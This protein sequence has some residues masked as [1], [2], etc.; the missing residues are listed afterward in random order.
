MKSS[1]ALPVLVVLLFSIFAFAGATPEAQPPSAQPASF[2]TVVD[3]FLRTEASYNLS[4]RKFTPVVETYLQRLRP[5][6]DFGFAPKSDEYFLGRLEL[7]K[8]Q[9][10]TSM[11]QQPGFL[12]RLVTTV[13]RQFELTFE[14]LG[15]ADMIYV[16][17]RG[18]DREHYD[19]KLARREFLG[20][21][22]CYVVDVTPK[23]KSGPGR[24][25][26]RIWVEDQGYNIVRA[27]GLFS[28][29]IK[30]NTYFLHFDSWRLNL[31]PNLW[32]PAYVYVEESDRDY[33][34]R[35]VMHLKA[36]TRFWGYDL[37]NPAK[38][39]ELAG[40]TIESVD[41]VSDQSGP[42]QDLSP[43]QAQRAW[44]RMAED[45]VLAR[46]EKA[47]L[48]APTGE[49]DKV[50]ATVVNNL[51]ITNNLNLQFDV[52]ARV[53]LTTPLESF[54]VGNTI[55]I[56]RGLLDVLPDEATLAAVLAHELAHITLGHGFDSKYAF[57]DRVLFPDEATLRKFEFHRSAQ[58][59]SDAD[60]QALIYLQNSPYKD[61]LTNVGLFLES[62]RSRQ[63]Q[64][65]NLIR[66]HLGTPIAQ[67]KR[68]RMSS[69]ME[70]APKL[71]PR[72]VDQIASLPLGGRIR[73]DP[74]SDRIELY[75]REAVPLSFPKEK[76]PFEVTPVYP[77]LTRIH[78]PEPQKVTGG[79]LGQ[80]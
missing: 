77:Y 16:D 4:V 42:G 5:D 19:F 39:E 51:E 30:R 78:E 62:L 79:E 38:Q 63:P 54:T 15:F 33:G 29:Q 43:V 67:G 72:R 60:S 21:L 52:R 27:T 20:E 65:T 55:V 24:F 1:R 66:A 22:R 25:L 34:M 71:E 57:G 68:V 49:V 46:L 47:G 74:W 40:M 8:I 50:L 7:T 75:K 61:K 14:A 28:P 13:P 26:G 23:P 44:N 12:H 64:L 3:N 70:S 32:L 10:D 58:E 31:K 36:Q 11:L 76:M 53:L 69:V 59:E 17:P 2:E 35:R 45:N 80:K 37:R 6:K 9:T 41:P 73:V 18:L 56:S 48:L